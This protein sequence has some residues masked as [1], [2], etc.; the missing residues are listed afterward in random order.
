MKQIN[1]FEAKTHLSAYVQDAL[2]GEE[3]IIAKAGKPL[4][5]LQPLESTKR[6]LGGWQGKVKIASDFD[7]W[8]PELDELF[9]TTSTQ[10]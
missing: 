6:K 1:M 7:D 3:V 5:R 2:N 10:K 9:G 8:S 4:V